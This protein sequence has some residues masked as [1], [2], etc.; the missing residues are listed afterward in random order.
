MIRARPSFWSGSLGFTKKSKN[1]VF[2]KK[3]AFVLK[4]DYMIVI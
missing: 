4:I 2:I 3:P 1:M